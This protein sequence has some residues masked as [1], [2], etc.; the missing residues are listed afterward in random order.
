MKKI[1]FTFILITMLAFGTLLIAKLSSKAV[2]VSTN[3][4]IKNQNKTTSPSKAPAN[5]T[6]QNPTP[7]ATTPVTTTKTS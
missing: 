1:L 5:T 6:Y 7:A 2:P 4:P 3:K